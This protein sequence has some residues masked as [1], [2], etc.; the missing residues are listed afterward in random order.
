MAYNVLVTEKAGEDLDQIVRYLLLNLSNP[1]AASAFLDA[2]D[3]V[4]ARLE[5]TPFLYP[6]CR[7]PLLSSMSWR[8]AVIRGYL[9][10]YKVAEEEKTV[11]VE[12]F[13][14]GLEDYEQ[15]L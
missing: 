9:M 8:K 10:L 3:A 4:Y 5:E 11:Y 12:R 7:Q 13:F 15:K 14:S 1:P 6:L 2:V